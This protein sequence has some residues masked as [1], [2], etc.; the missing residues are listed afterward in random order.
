MAY[1]HFKRTVW[2]KYIQSELERKCVLVDWC[3]KQFQGE[4]KYAQNVKILGVGNPTIIDYKG[5]P[6][7]DPE[8]IEDSSQLLTIDQAKAFNF[9][10]DDVD[11][12]QSQPGLMET[13]MKNATRGMAKE[14]DAFVGSKAVDAGGSSDSLAITTAANAKKAIDNGI[15][16]LRENDVAIDDDVVIELPYFMYL[17]FKDQLIELKTNNDELIK[18]GIVGMYDNCYVRTS[19]NLYNDGT[20]TYGMIRTKDAIA[21]ASAVDKVEAYRPHPLFS[22]AVKGLNV[23]GAKVVRPEQL[24]ALKVHK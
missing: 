15:L 18:K 6:I 17:L 16:F 24:Y 23:Y 1:E 10:V 13:L 3:N 20:D 12:A 5:Q 7:G 11:E 2:S 22:D 4:A 21:F 14:R 9:A 19:N 8:T